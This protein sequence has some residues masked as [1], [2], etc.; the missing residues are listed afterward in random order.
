MVDLFDDH[1]QTEWHEASGHGDSRGEVD[2][3]GAVRG[4]V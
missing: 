2:D 3:L 4:V 1:L